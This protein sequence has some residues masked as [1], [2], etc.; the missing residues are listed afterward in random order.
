MPF[1]GCV[2]HGLHLLVKD[3]LAATKVKLGRPVADY[4]DGYRFEPLLN[5]AANCKKVVKYFHNH[6][7]LKAMLKKAFLFS[8]LRMLVMVAPTW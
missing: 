7:A 1:Q 8:K 6:H 3:V 4:P 5:F 2:A